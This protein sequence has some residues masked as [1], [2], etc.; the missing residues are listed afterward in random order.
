ME[1]STEVRDEERDPCRQGK[2]TEMVIYVHRTIVL[3][4]SELPPVIG[5]SP[6][7]VHSLRVVVF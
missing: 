1:N 4:P 5:A 7:V 6:N 2:C 3:I